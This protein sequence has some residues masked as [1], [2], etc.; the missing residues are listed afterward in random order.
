MN[1]HDCLRNAPSQASKFLSQSSQISTVPF[2]F[3]FKYYFK[4]NDKFF[5]GD[6]F[7]GWT[8]IIPV[9]PSTCTFGSKGLCDILRKILGQAAHI[10]RSISFLRKVG[11]ITQ[12]IINLFPRERSSQS[13]SLQSTKLLL[14]DNV[15]A[16][17]S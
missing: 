16:D 14:K 1:F 7:S 8:E 5:F 4:L 3:I 2:E 9:K 17:V 11:S 6:L 12:T 13:C 10:R 15:N